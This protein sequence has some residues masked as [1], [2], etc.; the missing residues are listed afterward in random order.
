MNYLNGVRAAYN[1]QRRTHK[2]RTIIEKAN[3]ASDKDFKT[4]YGCKRETYGALMAEVG[5]LLAPSNHANSNA[6][7]EDERM[8]LFLKFIRKNEEYNDIKVNLENVTYNFIFVIC[9][10]MLCFFK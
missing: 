7:S 8:L 4:Y 6:L 2:P 5:P 1:I 10:G 3:A 9:F